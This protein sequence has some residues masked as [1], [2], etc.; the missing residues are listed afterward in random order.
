MFN[1]GQSFTYLLHGNKSNMTDFMTRFAYRIATAYASNNRSVHIHSLTWD[2]I[3]HV[4]WFSEPKSHIVEET[5]QPHSSLT[6]LEEPGLAGTCCLRPGKGQTFPGA[7]RF[8]TGSRQQRVSGVQEPPWSRKQPWKRVMRD[9]VRAEQVFLDGHWGSGSP[10]G[11][12]GHCW[13]RGR[14]FGHQCQ[15]HR[16]RSHCWKSKGSPAE[17]GSWPQAHTELGI[18]AGLGKENPARDTGQNRP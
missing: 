5:K 3:H 18:S 4:Q 15:P 14:S 10:P 13:Q 11:L 8:N 7:P 17:L 6:S 2:K 9:G 16:A 1:Q 12:P